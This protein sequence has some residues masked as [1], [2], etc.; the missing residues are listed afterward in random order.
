MKTCREWIVLLGVMALCGIAHGYPKAH[1]PFQKGKAPPS[2]LLTECTVVKSQYLPGDTADYPSIL[3]FVAPNAPKRTTLKLERLIDTNS[4]WWRI[5]VLDGKGTP[6]S[7]PAT[8]DMPSYVYSV[9]SAD[10]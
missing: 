6:I 7:T 10:L 1:A 8:N 9:R 4:C 3:Y 2:V 5:T